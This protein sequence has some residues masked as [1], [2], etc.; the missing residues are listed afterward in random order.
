MLDTRSPACGVYSTMYIYFT[1]GRV[2]YQLNCWT[3]KM[4]GE[5]CIY[6]V[7]LHCMPS[8]P[9]RETT[10]VYLNKKKDI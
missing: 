7:I 8:S 1:C 6:Y 10:H 9:N 4:M 5:H 2:T 3:K